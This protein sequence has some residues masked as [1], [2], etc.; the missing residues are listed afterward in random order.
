[1]NS[2]VRPSSSFTPAQWRRCRCRVAPAAAC[3][4]R[5]GA[6]T[7]TE[8][9]R[10][11]T[12]LAGALLA[13][14]DA[15]EIRVRRAPEEPPPLRVATE[16]YTCYRWLPAVLRELRLAHP[17]HRVT[18][19]VEATRDP[20]AALLRGALDLAI[21]SSARRDRRLAVRAAFDD[22][23]VLVTSPEHAPARRAHVAARDL[24]GETLFTYD[25]PFAETL[26]SRRVF[27]PARIRPARVHPVPFTEAIVE[28]VA[29]GLGVAALAKWAVAAPVAAGRLAQTRITRGGLRRNWQILHHRRA[30]G[31]VRALAG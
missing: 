24:A 1:M 13:E 7:P 3:A 12:V 9:G 25:A 28:L 4:R 8:A 19:S 11:L 17:R 16:C 2:A 21:V 22:E 31:G 23:L 20:A 10:E 30:G 29:S 6:M 15:A 18:I 14:L 27:A 5:P 26:I